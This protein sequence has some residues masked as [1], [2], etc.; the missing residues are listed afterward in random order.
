MIKKKASKQGAVDW[1][2]FNVDDTLGRLQT[3][4]KHGLPS[5]EVERRLQRFGPNRLPPPRRHPVWL[6]FLL[7]FHNVLI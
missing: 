5:Q 2:G 1:H 6:R 4:R 7:Q 3:D